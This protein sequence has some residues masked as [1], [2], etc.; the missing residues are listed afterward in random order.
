MDKLKVGIVGCGLVSRR[1]HIPSWLSDPRVNVVALCDFDEKALKKA[2][3][4]VIGAKTYKNYLDMLEKE[5]LDIVDVATPPHTHERIILDSIERGTNVLSEKP[6]TLSSSSCTKISKSAESEGVIVGVVQNHRYIPAVR[7]A[8]GKVEAG[9][10]GEIVC[11]NVQ[12]FQAIPG[13]WS[14]SL[15]QFNPRKGGGLLYN[16]VIH[17]VDIVNWFIDEIS[18]VHAVGG[19]YIEGLEMETYVACTLKTKKKAV[20]TL[21]ASLVT[22]AFYH[23]MD[24]IGTAGAV[25]IDFRNNFYR[26]THS[27]LTPIEEFKSGFLKL[28]KATLSLFRGEYMK[29]YLAFHEPLIKDFVTSVVEGRRPPVTAKEAEKSLRVIE[30]MFKSLETGKA[31]NVLS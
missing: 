18:I 26:I 22:G 10:I 19:R 25:N 6:L 2:K 7:E 9:N 15:W 31:V 4:M 3:E 24:V 16:T 12:L 29:G 20:G 23:E 28:F 13:S 5:N 11:F 27:H 14:Y 1:A 21:E 8:K 30:A 17:L